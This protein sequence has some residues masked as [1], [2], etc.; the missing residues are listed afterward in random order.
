MHG[1]VSRGFR[2]R[3]SLH[4]LSRV[5]R[6]NHSHDQSM[7]MEHTQSQFYMDDVTPNTGPQPSVSIM[8]LGLPS[9]CGEG[10]VAV[11]HGHAHMRDV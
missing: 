8:S 7:Q 4:M 11:T 9:S 3:A 10:D 2:F 1:S 6:D 5:A